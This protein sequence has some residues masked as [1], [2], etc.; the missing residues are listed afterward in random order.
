[1]VKLGNPKSTSMRVN[2]VFE[3]SFGLRD[4][5]VFS[6][7]IGFYLMPLEEVKKRAKWATT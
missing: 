7:V 3:N 1:M 5:T 6:T 2:T 4:I